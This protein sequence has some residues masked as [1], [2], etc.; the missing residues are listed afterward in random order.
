MLFRS[1][2][3]SS[4]GDCGWFND[5]CEGCQAHG[6]QWAELSGQDACFPSDFNGQCSCS[7][8]RVLTNMA[9]SPLMC[10]LPSSPQPPSS[11]PRG[12]RW[13]VPRSP[14]ALTARPPASGAPPSTS[15][16][17]IM[18]Q[19]MPTLTRLASAWAGL[20]LQTAPVC[21]RSLPPYLPLHISCSL[22]FSL[23][24]PLPPSLPPSL[25]LTTESCSSIRTCDSCFQQP[26]CGW[27]R[28]PEDTGLGVCMEGGFLTP[29]APSSCP[30]SLWYFDECPGELYGMFSPLL[31]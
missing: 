2:Y 8:G 22:S 24:P 18:L 23:P 5:S 28:G 29:K 15:A 7:T 26:G 16:S 11:P 10:S 4:A 27:C 14:H 3:P 12:V 9:F 1:S 31:L 30:S 17:T 21:S 13:P 20:T 25:P 19:P 6:C